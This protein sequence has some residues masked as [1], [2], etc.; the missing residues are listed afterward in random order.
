MLP[1]K[2]ASF[3]LEK[4]TGRLLRSFSRRLGYLHD[5]ES[6]KKIVRGWLF[7]GGHYLICIN[8]TSSALSSLRMSRRWRRKPLWMPSSV[9]AAKRGAATSISQIKSAAPDFHVA[10]PRVRTQ[11][12]L[13]E[14]HCFF[15]RFST[16]QPNDSA[17]SH[18]KGLF[19]FSCPGT[20]ASVEQRLRIVDGLGPEAGMRSANHADSMHFDSILQTGP[21]SSSFPIRVRR[22]A[23]EYGWHPETRSEV[24]AWYQ[25]ALGYTEH[26]ALSNEPFSDKV[27]SL[28]ASNFEGIWT[29]AGLADEIES[30][31]RAIAAQGFLDR[32]LESSLR[33]ARPRMENNSLCP[34][35]SSTCFGG[36]A[37]PA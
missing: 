28:L 13:I 37:P 29:R 2:A 6:A 11:S 17:R 23:K 15:V 35:C 21:F 33:Y 14:R 26:L 19:G 9:P 34:C 3:F 20:H 32:G 30:V 22:A 1:G 5:C 27:K 24:V 8:W 36:S 4:T 31:T 10:I 16:S 7:P 12:F 25:A 18:L